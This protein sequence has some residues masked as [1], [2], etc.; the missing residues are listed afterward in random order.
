MPEIK[1]IVAT[2]GSCNVLG[3]VYKAYAVDA[4]YVDFDD[5][6]VDA[7][8]GI[9]NIGMLTSGQWGELEFDDDENVALFNEVSERLT[10]GALVYNGTGLMSFNGLS[11]YKINAAGLAGLCCGVVI[12]WIHY[13]GL[14]RVQGIDVHPETLVATR[15]KQRA[16]INP[17]INSGTGAETETLVYNTVHQG[18]YPSPT[19]TLTDSQIEAL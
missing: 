9:T 1:D 2:T 5:I 11:Q 12:I 10:G 7:S 17:D 15:S 19:T 8:G 4:Q 6:T 13:S 14:R 18:R 3:G 16:K